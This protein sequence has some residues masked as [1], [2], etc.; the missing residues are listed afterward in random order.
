MEISHASQIIR[1]QKRW[2]KTKDFAHI[3]DEQPNAD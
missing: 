2:E 1:N 3:V